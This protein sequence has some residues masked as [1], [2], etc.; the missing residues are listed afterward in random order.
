MLKSSVAVVS[1]GAILGI[2][3]GPAIS[4]GQAVA[5]SPPDEV[6]RIVDRIG[7]RIERIPI[8]DNHAHPGYS[9][10]PDLDAMSAPPGGETYRI[11]A[12]NP[13]FVGAAKAMSG[14]PYADLSPEHARWLTDRKKNRASAGERIL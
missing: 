6:K 10:D 14:Y 1:L 12:E 9:D 7:P 13:E 8:F 3:Q 5:F 11:R 2:F 4:F